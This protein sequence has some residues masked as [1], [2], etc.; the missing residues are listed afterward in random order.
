MNKRQVTIHDIA[1]EL[2]IAASTVSRALSNHPRISQATKKLVLE[3]AEKMQYKPNAVASSL[4][5]GQGN[6]IGVIVPLINRHFFANVIHGIET[7][8]QPEGYHIIICQSTELLHKEIENIKT[9]LQNRVNGIIISISA[10]TRDAEH[11]KEV[12]KAG[13]PLVQ[14]DRSLEHFPG[15]Q[16]INDDFQGGYQATKHLI[17]QGYRNIAHF[18][19]PLFV[20][21]YEKRYAGYRKALEDHGMIPDKQLL[22]EGV[23]T[24][25]KGMAAM[26]KILKGDNVPDAIF[27]AGDYAALGA[28]LVAKEKGINV[29]AE[30]GV[31]G[32]VNEPFTEWLDPSLTTTEQF[33]AEQGRQAAQVLL[34]QIRTEKTLPAKKLLIPPKLIIRNSSRKIK[35]AEPYS[36]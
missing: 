33:G 31:A 16:V 4:R 29:P 13:I 8:T 24:R 27:A 15:S 26:E 36:I 14:F 9:L 25:E 3:T 32:Y 7:I 21:L 17:D 12:V 1:R 10:E 30:L 35:E 34:E 23:I 5:R 20:S 2:N 11:F 18:S 22:F 6:T 19:G 28:L